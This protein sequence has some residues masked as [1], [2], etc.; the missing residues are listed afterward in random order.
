MGDDIPNDGE[1]QHLALARFFAVKGTGSRFA[2]P[3]SKKK[4]CGRTE[5]DTSSG[6]SREVAEV[7]VD[8]TSAVDAKEL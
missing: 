8:A 7:A 1:R 4:N 3:V 2:R 6:K 5:T